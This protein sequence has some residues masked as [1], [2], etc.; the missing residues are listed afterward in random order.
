V[1]DSD[2]SVGM[3]AL[4]AHR[5]EVWLNGPLGLQ[6]IGG[7]DAYEVPESSIAELW[8]TDEALWIRAGVG[9]RAWAARHPR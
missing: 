4:G 2:V 7:L 9:P 1:V 3:G 8:V 5:D 6:L